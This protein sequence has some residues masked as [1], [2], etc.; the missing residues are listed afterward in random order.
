MVWGWIWGIPS[1]TTGRWPR[2][3]P[4]MPLPS[5]LAGATQGLGNIR[6]TVFDHHALWNIDELFW[7]EGPSG[8][9]R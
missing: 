4:I 3:L 8:A 6:L 9:R 7:R 2:Y 5:P 1:F